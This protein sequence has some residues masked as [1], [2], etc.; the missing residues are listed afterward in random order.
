M[1]PTWLREKSSLKCEFP[2]RERGNEVPLTGGFGLR[3]EEVHPIYY[4]NRRDGGE[5]TEG[6]RGRYRKLCRLNSVKLRTYPS[7]GFYF[8]C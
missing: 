8:L 1:G 6:W 2:L 7:G 5:C 3:L 4:F